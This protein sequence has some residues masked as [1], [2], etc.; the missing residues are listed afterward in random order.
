MKE[1]EVA[2]KEKA[3][4][5][6]VKKTAEARKYAAQQ[7]ADAKLYET[8]KASEAELFE[9]QEQAEASKQAEYDLQV[10]VDA[11][12]EAKLEREKKEDAARIE[13]EKELAAIE[14]AKQEAYAETVAKIMASVT[15]DLVAA[16]TS[17]SN[18]S[19]LETVTQAM[20]PYAIAQGESVAE[21]TNK[22]LRGTT[23]E[24]VIENMKDFKIE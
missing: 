3:L 8:Q 10:I 21:V 17:K 1:R 24:E 15:P 22:L 16:M 4:E 19:M 7:D 20:A 12:A 5:A 23:L 2:I 6:E 18:A 14:K 11:I 13:T 9:R